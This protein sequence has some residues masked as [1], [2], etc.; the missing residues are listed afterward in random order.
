LADVWGAN[1]TFSPASRSLLPPRLSAE[2][3]V[4][5]AFPGLLRA[6]FGA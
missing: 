3:Q 5:D 1:R 4:D 2:R 6:L